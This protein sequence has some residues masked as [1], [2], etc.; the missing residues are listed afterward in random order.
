M[1]ERALSRLEVPAPAPKPRNA[2]MTMFTDLGCG[3]HEQE[4]R[5][6]IAG[7]FVDLAKL[8]TSMVSTLPKEIIRKKVELYRKY[9]VEAFPGGVQM[10]HALYAHGMDIA[11]YVFEEM[12]DL[13]LRV[14]EVSDN[15][16]DLTLESKCKLIEKGAKEHGLKILAEAGDEVEETPLEALIHDCQSCKEA[17][18]YKVLLE[19]AELMD[20]KTGELKMHYLDAIKDAV[21]LEHIIFELPWVWLENVHWY[22]SF[23][24]LAVMVKKLGPEVNLG[25]IEMS[26]LVY[27]Q[28]IRN[29]AG[30][31]LAKDRQV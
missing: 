2:G 31:K 27:A 6:Q 16:L 11:D 9:G 7:D 1:T 4:D 15:Y 3:L 5:M 18:A 24:S 25:N 17:G 28:M 26:M 19:A 23:S 30:T 14:V 29:G 21:G 10:E 8:A 12:K 20:K 22:Q 13:G